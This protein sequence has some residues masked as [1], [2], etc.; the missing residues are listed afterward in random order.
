M[1]FD[2]ENEQLVKKDKSYFLFFISIII[3]IIFALF[4]I[5]YFVFGIVLLITEYK[6]TNSCKSSNLWEYTL[7]CVLINLVKVFLTKTRFYVDI[8]FCKSLIF[9][10]FDSLILLFGYLELFENS[11]ND[12]INSNIWNYGIISSVIQFLSLIFYFYYFLTY[13]KV[14]ICKIKTPCCCK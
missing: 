14:F 4:F 12:L 8:S 7:C 13:I 1:Y 10:I 3:Y 11:C 2:R 6:S 5:G 9:L